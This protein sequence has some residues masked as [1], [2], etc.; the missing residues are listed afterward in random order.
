MNVS[1]AGRRF[2]SWCAALNRGHGAAMGSSLAGLAQ[3]VEQLPC[4]HLVAG[5]TPA[6]GIK[7]NE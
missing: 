5:S 1:S 7:S 4:K 3:L 6:A 2:N